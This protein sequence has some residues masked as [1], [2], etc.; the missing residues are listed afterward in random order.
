MEMVKCGEDIFISNDG[1]IFLNDEN[2][3]E[4]EKKIE[5]QKKL[6]YI[7]YISTIISCIG[8]FVFM[9]IYK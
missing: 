7:I 4:H 1:K 8:L 9:L 2:C 3:L 5:K 6:N